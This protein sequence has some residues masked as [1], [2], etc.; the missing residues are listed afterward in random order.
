MPCSASMSCHALAPIALLALLL[1]TPSC[2]SRTDGTSDA[3]D[4]TASLGLDVQGHRGARGLLPENTL[5]GFEHALELGVTTLEL[6]LG[7]SRDGVVVVTH[8]PRVD[9]GVCLDA[10]GQVLG[11]PGPRILDLDLAEIQRL[12][13]GSLNPDPKRFPEPPRRNLPGARIPTLAEVFELVA[14]RG[15]RRVRFNVEPKVEPG[16]AD[17][18]APARFVDRV[19]DVIER[20][21][22]GERVTLQC[23]DWHV[24]RL[25]KA[26]IPT[27]RTA[28]LLGAPDTLDPA[29][30]DGLALED[31]GSV[32]RLLIAARAFVDDFSPHWSHLVPGRGYLG[33]PV[34][35]YQR[36]G[37]GVLPW[38]VNDAPT[39]E[40]L[41][42]LGVDGIITDRPDLLLE[43]AR[44]R[45]V[46][47][48]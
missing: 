22:V 1:S 21:G 7:L 30:Q 24:L 46:R 5:A 17:T 35:A 36:A 16:S 37:F 47:V 19:I 18:P 40:R 29:W 25:A 20:H 44:Q 39:M 8:D 3:A 2:V 31:H 27:L 42:E 33:A 15:D 48:L 14:R 23:F 10:E 28:A 6:D 34:S 13:C 4:A 43:V 32:L 9:P 11:A 45:G 26:R 38:T 41:I 12:D